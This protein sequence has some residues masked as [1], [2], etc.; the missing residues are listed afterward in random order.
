MCFN[1][2]G[3]HLAIGCSSFTRLYAWDFEHDYIVHRGTG[4]FLS[5][6]RFCGV[7]LQRWCLAALNHIGFPEW[8]HYEKRSAPAPDGRYLARGEEDI[9][10]IW[11]SN[12]KQNLLEERVMELGGRLGCRGMLIRNAQGIEKRILRYMLSRGADS[13]HEGSLRDWWLRNQVAD[14]TLT[15]LA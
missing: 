3:T 12:P 7:H 5:T 1:A 2:K 14:D 9:V 8:I 11:R 10:E 15:S 4:R 13:I 6:Y